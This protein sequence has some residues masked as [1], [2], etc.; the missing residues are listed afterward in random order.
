MIRFTNRPP[1]KYTQM[2]VAKMCGVSESMI[3]LIEK[4]AMKKMRLAITRMAAARGVSVEEWVSDCEV[5]E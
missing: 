2:E 1:R 3:W 4:R 5:T